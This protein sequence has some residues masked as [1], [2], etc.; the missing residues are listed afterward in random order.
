[1]LSASRAAVLLWL[2][3]GKAKYFLGWYLIDDIAVTRCRSYFQLNSLN[4]SERE[5]ATEEGKQERSGEQTPPPLSPR[6]EGVEVS[7]WWEVS[8]VEIKWAGK[9][10][11]LLLLY[12]A[13]RGA[14]Q[15]QTSQ[16]HIRTMQAGGMYVDPRQGTWGLNL[17]T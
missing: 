2:V 14:S 12:N 5:E 16:L 1:M 17:G 15:R 4:P 9:M 3:L 10:E 6:A 8:Q 7:Q 13:R 11:R